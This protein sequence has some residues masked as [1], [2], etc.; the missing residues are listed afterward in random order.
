MS[1]EEVERQRKA[2]ERSET[3]FRT[4]KFSHTE[5][6]RKLCPEAVGHFCMRWGDHGQGGFNSVNGG[7]AQGGQPMDKDFALWADLIDCYEAFE[8]AKETKDRVAMRAAVKD[9][10]EVR[11]FHSIDKKDERQNRGDLY[12]EEKPSKNR[13]VVEQRAKPADETKNLK[14]KK[15]KSFN[16]TWG[17]A[18]LI[19]FLVSSVPFLGISNYLNESYEGICSRTFPEVEKDWEGFITPNTETLNRYRNCL[20]IADSRAENE[21]WKLFILMLILVTPIA[22]LSENKK[23]SLD[24]IPATLLFVLNKLINK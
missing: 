14:T 11:E 20:K 21:S 3:F 24:F 2:L 7:Y 16:E 6:T 22:W 10:R 18:L 12:E 9:L 1:E 15:K 17:G 23:I 19:T 13:K 4:K 5:K 8:K